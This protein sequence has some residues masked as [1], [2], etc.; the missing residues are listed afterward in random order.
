MSLTPEQ[1]QQN[2]DR[3]KSLCEKTG[4]RAEALSKMLSVFEERLALCPASSRT[5][6][7][8]AF[9]GGLVEHSLR[10][11]SNATKIIKAFE[12][13]VKKESLIIG[14][15][16][17]DLGKLGDETGEYYLPQESDWHREKL[18]ELY[19]HN[20]EIQYMTVGQRGVYL[21]QRFG[22]RL[23]ADEYLAILLNDGWILQENKSYCM[24]EPMLVTAVQHADYIATKQEKEMTTKPLLNQ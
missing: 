20:K 5:E 6:Y 16:F 17:H 11:L 24:K 3:F 7:H 1:I 12:W 23:E 15:L 13:T 22:V 4:D 2:W 9:P 19:I 8:N 21:M 10:V 14:C 18:G